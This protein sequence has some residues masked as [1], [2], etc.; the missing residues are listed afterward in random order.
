[1]SLA[2]MTDRRVDPGRVQD[3]LGRHFDAVVATDANP[4]GWMMFLC[5]DGSGEDSRLRLRVKFIWSPVGAG[6]WLYRILP[7]KRA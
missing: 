4:D 5:F 2:L 1:M 6:G 3:Y 7:G